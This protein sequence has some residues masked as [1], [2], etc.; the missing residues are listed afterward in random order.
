MNKATG[1]LKEAVRGYYCIRQVKVSHACASSYRG[2][3]IHLL[4]LPYLYQQKQTAHS[5]YNPF[6]FISLFILLIMMS[7]CSGPV[8][9]PAVAGSFYPADKERL[10]QTVD[11]FISQAEKREVNG[12]LIALIAPHAGYAFSGHVAGYTYRQ[13]KGKDIKTVILIGPSHHSAFNGVSI[14]KQGRMKTPLGMIKINSRI[15]RSLI[16]K[17]ADITFYPDAFEKEHSLEVQLPFLQRALNNFQIVPILIGNPTRKSFE[18]LTEKLTEILRD[19]DH[20]ILIAST[21]LSHYHDYE[22][23][24]RMDHRD[25][26]AIERMSIE[27]VERLLYNGEIEMCGAYPVLYTMAVARNLGATNG[28]LFRYANSGDV[29]GDRSRVVGYAAMGLYRTPLTE[30]QKRR[31]LEIAKKT[32]VSYVKYGRAPEFDIH[33]RRLMANGATFVTINRHG[34]LR[35]CIGN[36]MPYMP[37]Y[38]S[39]IKNAIHACSHDPR[40]PPMKKEE[41]D[42]IE[43][44]VSV[45]S[46]L[47][48]LRDEDDIKVGRDGLYIVKGR[49][50]GILLPQVPVEFGWERN[51][52]LKQVS[53]KAGLPEDAWKEAKL[54]TFTADIIR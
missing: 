22:T 31:L 5:G 48:P 50:S 26:D 38:K 20:I 36:I 30:A 14:Y 2:V 51:T 21:D 47:K 46:P 16:N 37:L 28:V 7:S 25:I 8:K 39:V 34:R 53:L 54:Y 13:L 4:S 15:A 10:I 18:Y 24:V 11:G 49:Q 3:A 42:G 41:L 9:E 44:E 35:G 33:D 23:A 12:R 52:F 6:H 1:S 32:I 45:L 27:D 17:E 19:N 29:T 43:V 40:F